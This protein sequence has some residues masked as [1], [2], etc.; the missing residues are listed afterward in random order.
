MLEIINSDSL[1]IMKGYK[2][3]EFDLCLCDPPYG[4]NV[5]NM[6]MGFGGGVAK[7]I[8]YGKYQWDMKRLPKE[9]FDE[10]FRISK[11]QIIFGG[12]YYTDYLYPSPCWIIW[13]KKKGMGSTDFADCEICWT[14]FKSPSRI[15]SYLWRGMLQDNMKEKDVRVHPA[16]KPVAVIRWIL[17]R[18]SENE[19]TIID[20]F[21]GSGS[22]LVACKQLG[23]KCIGIEI[24]KEYCEISTNR[25]YNTVQSF[26]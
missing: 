13:D 16:Q 11:N 14:S 23:R 3:K 5:G 20:P 1:P 24:S 9:Y 6:Q 10:I 18:Y 15:I 17:E 21:M 19:D 7:H 25:L 26:V 8:D 4:I 22:S 2:D 12:N